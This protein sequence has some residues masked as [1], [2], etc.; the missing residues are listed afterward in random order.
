MNVFKKSAVCTRIFVPPYR[1]KRRF[2]D[3]RHI[4]NFPPAYS[5][6]IKKSRCLRM[7]GLEVIGLLLLAA[8]FTALQFGWLLETARV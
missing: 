2:C 3:A 1:N 4:G 7:F 8:S 5:A 6:I